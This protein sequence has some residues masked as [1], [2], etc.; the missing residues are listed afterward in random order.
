VL[1][2]APGN[3]PP[4]RPAVAPVTPIPGAAPIAISTIADPI[5]NSLSPG[6]PLSA[7]SRSAPKGL[8]PANSEGFR[9]AQQRQFVNLEDGQVVMVRYDDSVRSYCALAKTENLPSGPALYRVEGSDIWKENSAASTLRRYQLPVRNAATLQPASSPAAGGRHPDDQ[10]LLQC[11]SRLLVDAENFFKNLPLPDRPLS[12]SLSP[13][14]NQRV[15]IEALYRHSEGVVMGENHIDSGSKLFLAENMATLAENGVRTL[16][17]E[18]LRTDVEQVHLE[19]FHKTGILSEA[20][21]H[22][23]RTFDGDYGNVPPGTCSYRHLIAMARAHGIRVQALD[24]AASDPLRELDIDL[25]MRATTLN[26]HAHQVIRA[27]QPRGRQGKWLAL[28]NTYHANG[29]P[30]QTMPGLARLQ[31]VTG[32]DVKDSMTGPAILAVPARKHRLDGPMGLVGADLKLSVQ[33]PWREALEV[34]LQYRKAVLDRIRSPQGIFRMTHIR[35]SKPT[36][37]ELANNDFF[38]RMEHLKNT[39]KEFFSWYGSRR[40]AKPEIPSLPT[41]SPASRIL[42]RLYENNNGLVLGADEGSITGRKFLIDNMDTLS[43]LKVE[44]L[45]VQNFLTDLDQPFIDSF[46]ATGLVSGRLIDA[47]RFEDSRQALGQMRDY[48]L[49]HLLLSAQRYGIKIQALDTATSYRREA[50]LDNVRIFNYIAHKIIDNDQQQ[51]GT[52]KWLALVLNVHTASVRGEPGLAQLQGAPGLRTVAIEPAAA[53]QVSPDSGYVGHFYGRNEYVRSDL[54]LQVNADASPGQ[55]VEQDPR[56]CLDWETVEPGF[57]IERQG[58][59]FILVQKNIHTGRERYVETIIEVR[60]GKYSVPHGAKLSNGVQYN[61]LADLA[62]GLRDAGIVQVADIPGVIP[63]T[64]RLDT[65]PQLHRPGMFLF[66]EAANGP[67]LINRSRDRSLTVTPIRRH[68]S[69]KLYI[70]HTRWGYDDSRLFD[71][72][73][74]LSNDLIEHVGLKPCSVRPDL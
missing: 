7:Y 18:R 28:V 58:D 35:L 42:E 37:A 60:D 22:R 40:P 54:K 73:D 26:Y 29:Y 45:Y 30:L 50:P 65:H 8:P 43:T 53:P 21:D 33:V 55:G 19:A 9:M 41:D 72:Q 71:S 36:E 2:G 32:L 31:G 12:P 27:D 49:Q 48:S 51:H 11:R 69:G 3:T 46:H 64:P 59:N 5:A 67:V 16:Y 34:P 62:W 6:L 68:S 47:L 13:D 38:Q 61:S 24:C 63:P 4:A 10:A 17:L 57:L 14:A 66:D 20:L 1:P 52:H 44:K 56:N 25:F 70:N 39:S 23:L 15:L 74:A